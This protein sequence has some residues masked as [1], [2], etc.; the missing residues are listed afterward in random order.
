MLETTTKPAGAQ[1]PFFPRPGADS[2]KR[3]L[4]SESSSAEFRLVMNVAKKIEASHDQAPE[5]HEKREEK[6]GD[7]DR[8]NLVRHI[9]VLRCL[10]DRA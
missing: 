3:L 7:E 8:S 2:F 10:T 5:Y 4:G 9:Q 1:T 6:D